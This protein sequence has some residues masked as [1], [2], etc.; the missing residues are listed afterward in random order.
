MGIVYKDQIKDGYMSEQI[1][2][3][4]AR[5]EVYEY[6]AMHGM[7]EFTIALN[8][9]YTTTIHQE[10]LIK[11]LQSDVALLQRNCREDKGE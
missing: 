8:I 7:T 11:K 2:I 9:L 6:L 4:D 10:E 1:N 5:K 3:E